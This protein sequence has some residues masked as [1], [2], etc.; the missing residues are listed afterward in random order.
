M[1]RISRISVTY[2]FRGAGRKRVQQSETKDWKA[3]KPDTRNIRAKRNNLD[4][5]SD[6]G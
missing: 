4:T 6:F 3:K 1:S 5:E 2:K